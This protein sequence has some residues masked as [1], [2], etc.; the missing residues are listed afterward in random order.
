VQALFVKKA[1]Q[2]DVVVDIQHSAL[3]AD[4]WK[5]LSIKKK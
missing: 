2:S 4:A 1:H 3:I 5:R